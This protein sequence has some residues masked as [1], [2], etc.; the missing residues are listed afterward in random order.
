MHALKLRTPTRSLLVGA[1]LTAAL[2]FL[3]LVA[4]VQ[5]APAPL[6]AEAGSAERANPFTT[7]A[8]RK[9][10]ILF[11]PLDERASS[12][13][14]ATIG[15]TAR[16][17]HNPHTITYVAASKPA[18]LN[19]E[20]GQLD[21]T[22]VMDDIGARF[23]SA[24]GNRSVLL[25]MVSS[26]SMYGNEQ[27]SFAFGLIAGTP[28]GSRV[29]RAMI[30][31]AQMRFYHPEREKARLTKMMLRYIGQIICGLPRNSDP[32]SVMYEPLISDTQFDRMVAKLPPRC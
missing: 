3:A 9:A 32:K 2:V 16:Y 15:A 30:A 25:V 7:T 29:Y 31:T 4:Q 1:A 23:K 6:L 20:R 26:G 28:A 5:A 10:T 14:S 11:V 27:I 13:I 19:R 8:A 21:G 12:L 24:Q 22:A 18:W 17:L